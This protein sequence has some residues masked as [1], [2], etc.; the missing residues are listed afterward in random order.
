MKLRQLR[1]PGFR[2]FFDVVREPE[3][4]AYPSM[5]VIRS[6]EGVVSAFK[7]GQAAGLIPTGREAFVVFALNARHRILGVH[8]V[9]IGNLTSAPI[10][11]REVFTFAIALGSAALVVAHNHPSGDATPS[12][13]DRAITN[14]LQESGDL[15]GIKVLDHLV[16][17]SDR[18]YSFA[19]GRH[20]AIGGEVTA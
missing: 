12:S 6:G 20:F 19:D 10:H 15:L 4:P 7:A 1:R 14:R 13:D 9:S 18:F 17:G 11:P 16:I 2:L 5:G 3:A 8:V